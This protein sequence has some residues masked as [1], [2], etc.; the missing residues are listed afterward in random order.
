MDKVQFTVYDIFGYLVPGIAMLVGLD[1]IWKFGLWLIVPA[2]VVGAGYATLG[3]YA[4]GHVLSWP[5][6]MCLQSNIVHKLLGGPV[7]L[8]LGDKPKW[9]PCKV[10]KWVFPEYFDDL[11]KSIIKGIEKKREVDGHKLGNHALKEHAYAVVKGTE[12]TRS[13]TD[14]FQVLYGYARNL[15]FTLAVVGLIAIVKGILT[16]DWPNGLLI[17]VPLVI[18]AAMFVRFL[19][20]YREYAKELLLSFYGMKE[21]AETEED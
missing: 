2:S 16:K 13:R 4:L 10:V 9:A 21:T 5:A 11:P 7:D 15:S 17:I 18:S 14:L 8:L 19:K 1:L 20:F 6:K 3:A 12:D